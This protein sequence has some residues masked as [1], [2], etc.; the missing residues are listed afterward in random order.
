[1]A[2][3]EK[4][5]FSSLDELDNAIRDLSVDKEARYE[6]IMETPLNQESFLKLSESLLGKNIS[7]LSLEPEYDDVHPP[8]IDTSVVKFP[9]LKSFSSECQAIKAVHFSA[10]CFPILESISIEQPCANDL[11]YFFT[12]LPNLKSLS[13]QF[14][15]IEDPSMFGPS[16]GRSP[17]L[18]SINCYKFWGLGG[19]PVHTLVMPQ[20]TYLDLYRSDDLTGLKIW[21]PKLLELQLRACYSLRV[22]KVLKNRPASYT[23]PE[24]D[25]KGDPSK[26]VV[27]IINAGLDRGYFEN[28]PRVQEVAATEDEDPFLC[29]AYL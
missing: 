8:T 24:Y 25:F 10:D 13:F 12:N 22:V 21:A 15:T 2:T 26:F 29:P 9:K 1:M 7:S 4:L 14:V 28:M 11:E 5:T 17:K 23:G 20:V 27:N 3:H 19:V 6:V 16:I 18:E